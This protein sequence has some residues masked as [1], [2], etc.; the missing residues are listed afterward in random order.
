MQNTM[1]STPILT[2]ELE[3]LLTYRMGRD[4]HEAPI[5]HMNSFC[6]ALRDFIEI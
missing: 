3:K 6:G 4:V 5:S 2:S 1:Y